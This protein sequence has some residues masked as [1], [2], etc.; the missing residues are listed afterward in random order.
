MCQGGKPGTGKLYTDDVYVAPPTPVGAWSMALGLRQ[1]IDYT[2]FLLSLDHNVTE[3]GDGIGGSV[4]SK[5]WV[6]SVLVR[7]VEIVTG[8]ERE[9]RETEGEGGGEGEEGEGGRE[10]VRQGEGEGEREAGARERDTQRDEEQEDLDKPLEDDLCQLWDASMNN[11]GHKRIWEWPNVTHNILGSMGRLE[12]CT[13]ACLLTNMLPYTY[14][15][16][17][18]NCGP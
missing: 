12:S 13:C 7:A 5:A 10:G 9:D 14:S 18:E 15:N 6:L 2:C 1:S 16:F 11:V 8:G 3:G 17:K 4:F